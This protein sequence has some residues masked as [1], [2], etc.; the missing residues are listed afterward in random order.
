[1]TYETLIHKAVPF[2]EAIQAQVRSALLAADVVFILEE[3]DKTVERHENTKTFADRRGSD[4][5]SV[6]Y[7]RDENT[8]DEVIEKIFSKGNFI[9]MTN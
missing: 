2:Q 1:M 8:R 5:Q 4:I 7:N 9:P 6:L 3:K